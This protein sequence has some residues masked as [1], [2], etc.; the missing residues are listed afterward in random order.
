MKVVGLLLAAGKSRRYGSDKR[1]QRLPGGDTLITHCAKRLR[2]AVDDV[3]VILGPGDE[4]LVDSLETLAVRRCI[5]PQADEGMGSSIRCGVNHTLDTDGWLIMPADLPLLRLETVQRIVS[6]LVPQR[7]VVPICH[8]ARGHP[9]AFSRRFAD[10]LSS[11]S[12]AAGGRT[13]LQR[14]HREV[15]WL[16]VHDP[17]I[18]RDMDTLRDQQS[19]WRLL[20]DQDIG[21]DGR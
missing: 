4:Q 19:L 10:E 8:G 12:G 3:L 5:N 15:D 14:H 20:S 11:L 16:N 18:Y 7:A 9:V 13:I 6:A 2:N 17:G 21:A 1:L